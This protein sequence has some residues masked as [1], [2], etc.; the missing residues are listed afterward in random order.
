MINYPS[1]L[2]ISFNWNTG[3]YDDGSGGGYP[4]YL[5]DVISFNSEDYF[6]QGDGGYFNSG[7]ITIS[8]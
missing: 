5:F 1:N 8:G 7:Y 3:P 6:G 4:A 2:E